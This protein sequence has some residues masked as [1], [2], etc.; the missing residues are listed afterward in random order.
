M[1]KSELNTLRSFVSHCERVLTQSPPPSTR[2]TKTCNAYRIA[3]YKE[4]E[5]VKRIIE[6]W[7]T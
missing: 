3:R 4:L 7:T 2:D 5:K 1:K 6:T